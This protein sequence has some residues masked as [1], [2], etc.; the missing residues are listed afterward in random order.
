[1]LAY[2]VKSFEF[3]TVCL[4]KNPLLAFGL[5]SCFILT[6]HLFSEALLASVVSTI[7]AACLR[8]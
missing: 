4:H 2:A 8:D 3:G 5:S 7:I 1:M 6:V